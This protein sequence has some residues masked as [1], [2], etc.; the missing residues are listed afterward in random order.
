MAQQQLMA[1]QQEQLQQQQYQMK[2]SIDEAKKFLQSTL[3]N[4]SQGVYPVQVQPSEQ[5][6]Q[7]AS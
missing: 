3:V 7:Q 6:Q 2:G 4:E 1:Q 5:A